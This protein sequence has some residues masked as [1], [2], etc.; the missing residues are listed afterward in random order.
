M[1]TM[2]TFTKTEQGFSG[3]IRTLALNVKATIHAVEKENDKAADFRIY[4]GATEFG[5]AWRKTSREGREY[6]S[7]KLDDPIFAAPFYAT[8]TEVEEGSVRQLQP[9]LV[10]IGGSAPRAKARGARLFESADRSS[11]GS[12]RLARCKPQARVLPLQP[13]QGRDIRFR[14]A[15]TAVVWC[16]PT[17]A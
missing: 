8:L 10:T 13:S 6:I 9:Y 7:A 3:T 1:A 12:E 17:I 14:F 15:P 5:A 4:A 11:A 16:Y 2:G